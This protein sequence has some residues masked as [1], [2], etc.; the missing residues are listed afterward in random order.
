MANAA[1]GMP[2]SGG[3]FVGI[4]VYSART[5][6]YGIG[7]LYCILHGGSLGSETVSTVWAASTPV[8]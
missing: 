8:P 1:H 6:Q 3:T 2:R 5:T 7:V 4:L